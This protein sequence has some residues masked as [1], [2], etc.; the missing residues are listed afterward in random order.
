M[1]TSEITLHSRYF[2]IRVRD[3]VKENNF[4]TRNGNCCVVK[5]SSG[6]AYSIEVSPAP[7]FDK[8]SI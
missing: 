6:P 1:T 5:Q 4:M 8:K 3:A 7:F 2:E